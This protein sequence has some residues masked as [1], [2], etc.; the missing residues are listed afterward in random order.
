MGDL[1]G[2]CERYLNKAARKTK[3]KTKK[4]KA[5]K[6]PCKTTTGPKSGPRLRTLLQVGTRERPPPGSGGQAP[7]HVLL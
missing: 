7:A 2:V 3:I 5:S 4:H 6:Q 1:C